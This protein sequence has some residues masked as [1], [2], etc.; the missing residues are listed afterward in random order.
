MHMKI[1]SEILYQWWRRGCKLIKA[2]SNC[3]RHCICIALGCFC[4]LIVIFKGCFKTIWVFANAAIHSFSNHFLVK[5]HSK[6]INKIGCKKMPRLVE[7]NASIE[8]WPENTQHLPWRSSRMMY[9]KF[10]SKMCCF[11]SDGWEYL[12]S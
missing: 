1:F 3:N 5:I 7:W 8:K 11:F 10:P 12:K 4:W 9:D 6:K 2:I